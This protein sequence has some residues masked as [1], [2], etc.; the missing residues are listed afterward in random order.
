[1]KESFAGSNPLLGLLIFLFL[2]GVLPIYLVT[3]F[4]KPKPVTA[5]GSVKIVPKCHIIDG[6]KYCLVLEP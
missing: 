6:D 3:Q 4:N 1:M 2:F 5:T